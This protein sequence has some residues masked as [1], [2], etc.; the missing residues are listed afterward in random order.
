[1]TALAVPHWVSAQ[2]LRP[3]EASDR[4]FEELERLQGLGILDTIPLGQR[5]GLEQAVRQA[6]EGGV[7][8]SG[9]G[10]AG[11]GGPSER[12]EELERL[13]EHPALA[14]SLELSYGWTDAR[15]RAVPDNGLGGISAITVPL[16]EGRGGR[17][18]EGGSNWVV[19]PDF[20]WRSG[21]WSGVL[22][23]RLRW[24]PGAGSEPAEGRIQEVWVEGPLGPVHLMI[25]RAP[26]VWGASPSGGHMHSGQARALDQVTVASGGTFRFPWIFRYMGPARLSLTVARLEGARAIPHSFLVSYKLSYKPF[27]SVE[28]GAAVLNHS[29]GEGAPEASLGRRLLDYLVLAERFSDDPDGAIS[30]MLAGFDVRWRVPGTRGSQAYGAMTIDDFGYNAELGRVFRQDASYLLGMFIP[31]LTGDGRIGLRAEYRQTGIRFYR[32]GQF[33]SGLT[34][35]GVVIGDPLGPDG[36]GGYLT[37]DARPTGRDRISVH[38]AREERSGDHYAAER[39]AEG[40]LFFTKVDD[41]PEETRSRVAVS[42]ERRWPMGLARGATTFL[43]GG[44]ERVSDFGFEAEAGGDAAIVELRVTL[45]LARSR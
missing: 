35:H 1:M 11:V 3:T 42:W 38:V 2:H 17:V 29:G 16:A 26:V 27:R 20:R 31:R 21:A 32:H 13:L 24:Q 45:D 14:A 39:D 18:L 7:G 44:Y 41:L 5:V 4:V 37:V 25:G 28:L 10:L 40:Y 43:R 8:P 15:A 6:L 19:E 36:R 23:S 12:T 34:F 9:P 30:N 22:R 33:A